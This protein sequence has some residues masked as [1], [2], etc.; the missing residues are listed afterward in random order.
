MKQLNFHINMVS[1][2]NFTIY[3]NR[4]GENMN[5]TGNII[6]SMTIFMVAVTILILVVL[7]PRNHTHYLLGYWQ[8]DSYV[9]KQNLIHFFEGIWERQS[10]GTS[11]SGRMTVEETIARDFPKSLYIILTAFFIS[12]PLGVC[13]GI[14]DFRN[15]NR[16]RSI[17]GHGTTWL[18]QSIPDFFLII[19]LQ[20][21]ILYNFRSIPI[22]G[23][24]DWYSF[25]FPSI[26]VSIYPTMYV[27]RITSS[28]MLGQNGQPYIQMAR[29]KGLPQ[30]IIIYKHMFLNCVGTILSHVS[31]VMLYIISNLLI[32]EYLSDYKGAAYRLFIAMDY[33]QVITKG[34]YLQ[35][36]P[37]MIIGFGICFMLLVL[38]AQIISQVARKYVDPR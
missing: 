19:C 7:L 17:L 22:F 35:Y 27:A 12:I 32:V 2:L 10:L 34:Q 30:K 29:A 31:S 6:K 24:E 16:K 5:S 8:F 28:S 23:H 4:L 38:F 20:W 25:I 1:G 15:A 14:F 21:I 9:Y 13:K 18:T 33:R 37:G 26:L 36:E 11:S 3:F